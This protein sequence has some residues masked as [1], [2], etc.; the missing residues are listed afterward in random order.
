MATRIE[1]S[2]TERRILTRL[3]DSA[4]G[5]ERVEDIHAELDEEDTEFVDALQTLEGDGYLSVRNI[6]GT[7][8]VGLDDPLL[9]LAV[10]QPPSA[11]C[12]SQEVGVC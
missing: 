2:S 7:I 9:M 10:P 4:T 8:V 12:Y 11:M 3:L 1:M 6:G 5:F